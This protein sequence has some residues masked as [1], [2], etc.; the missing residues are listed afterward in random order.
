[1]VAD[2]GGNEVHINIWNGLG[3]YKTIRELDLPI[4]IHFQKSGDRIFTNPNHAHHINWTVI[5]KL[6]ALMGVDSIHAGMLGGYSNESEELEKS[7]EILRSK[8]IMPALSCGMHP[9]IVNKITEKLGVDY[10][11]NVG[12]AI[13]GHAGGTRAGAIAMR[14]A[15]DGNFGEEY[16]TAIRDWGLQ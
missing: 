1:M 8:N 16:H 2:A 7:I 11:A 10:I 9:G 12:G 3:V 6:A 4:Y 14:Q 15:I 13:H 5:C